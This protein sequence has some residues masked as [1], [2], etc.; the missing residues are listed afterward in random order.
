LSFTPLVG[1]SLLHVVAEYGNV[2]A[3]RA[4]VELGADVNAPAAADE[5][6]LN[7]Q[8]PLYHTVNSNANRSEP[9]LRQPKAGSKETR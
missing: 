1:A 4:L 5:H 2:N 7:G 6:G 3:A 8:T 9:V